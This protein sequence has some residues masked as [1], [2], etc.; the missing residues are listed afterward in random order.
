MPPCNH[1]LAS[2]VRLWSLTALG[3]RVRNRTSLLRSMFTSEKLFPVSQ[4][5]QALEMNQV[6]E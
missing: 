1:S 2:A 5:S 3:Q 6:L 4:L